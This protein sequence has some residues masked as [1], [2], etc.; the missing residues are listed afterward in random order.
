LC[1]VVVQLQVTSESGDLSSSFEL[2]FHVLLSAVNSWSA[3]ITA[4]GG[5]SLPLT[6]DSVTAQLPLPYTTA[7]QDVIIAITLAD[8]SATCDAPL[9]RTLQL[10]SRGQSVSVAWT[11]TAESGLVGNTFTLSFSVDLSPLLNWQVVVSQP[12]GLL[13][14][15]T[16]ASTVAAGLFFIPYNNAG[17]TV[18]LEISLAD[19]ATIQPTDLYPVLT[20]GVRGSWTN[21]SLQVTAENGDVGHRYSV[22][23]F[24]GLSTDASWSAV[25]SV[26]GQSSTTV[27]SSMAA[28]AGAIQWP[29]TVAGQSA[30][31]SFTLAP[32]AS[33]SPAVLTPH[34]VLGNRGTSTKYT[35]VFTSEAGVSTF[36][37]TFTLIVSLS[38]NKNWNLVIMA[39]GLST[40]LTQVS[41]AA[42]GQLLLPFSAAKG[43]TKLTFTIP[44]TATITP[45]NT[46]PTVQMGARN[47]TVKCTFIVCAEDKT[48]GEHASAQ[49]S[50]H[51]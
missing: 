10:G 27:T 2:S 14:T 8:D 39:P 32:F 37:Y 35:V 28:S 11:V 7:G 33:I 31:I 15:L 16:D 17:T 41:S 3:L 12:S 40:V 38:N 36:P 46:A 4:P 43:L 30:T 47:T 1:S 45:N 19:G 22:C 18:S 5:I 13:A 26:V 21:Y 20:L 48:S 49:A 24:V 51:H 50:Q 34:I 25:V 29:Y 23:I 44:S 6:Q 42:A 9:L